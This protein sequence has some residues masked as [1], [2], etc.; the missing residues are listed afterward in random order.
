MYPKPLY[1]SVLPT[2]LML[3]AWIAFGPFIF[4]YFH[5]AVFFVVV[6]CGVI[7]SSLIGLVIYVLNTDDDEPD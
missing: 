7:T 1:L 4:D 3:V 5:P 2:L 6:L